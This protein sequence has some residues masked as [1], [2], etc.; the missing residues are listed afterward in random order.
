[1]TTARAQYRPSIRN[2][3]TVKHRS[4]KP[5][6]LRASRL[7]P[8]PRKS[9]TLHRSATPR[10]RAQSVVVSPQGL[11]VFSLLAVVASG[12]ALLFVLSLNWQRQ[13]YQ[14]NQ[15][16]VALRSK[17]YQTANEQRQ[18]VAVQQRAL[19][20]RENELRSRQGK[21]APIKLEERTVT[22]KVPDRLLSSS[23][24]PKAD[25]PEPVVGNS[26]STVSQA[27]RSSR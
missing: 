6:R 12:L 24:K 27:A 20:P 16:E 23:G 7:K 25:N 10:R 17:L 5:T 14:L 18:L 1:M 11:G 15:Q 4:V 2:T 26:R 9:R 22:A 21:L 19:S 3:Q 13:A 8:V